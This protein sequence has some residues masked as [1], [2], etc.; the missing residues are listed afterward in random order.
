MYAHVCAY[1]QECAE[2]RGQ[3][4]MSFSITLNVSFGNGYLSEPGSSDLGT[5]SLPLE[6][7]PHPSPVLL[8]PRL[9]L[10]GHRCMTSNFPRLQ[11]FESLLVFIDLTMTGRLSSSLSSAGKEVSCFHLLH[12]TVKSW[13]CQDFEGSGCLSARISPL[14][15][16]V[17]AVQ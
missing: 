10:G 2:A 13:L 4:Y 16:E 17:L 7:S 3:S 5:T 1:V 9:L 6:S 14:D 11:S 8:K 12:P 15:S